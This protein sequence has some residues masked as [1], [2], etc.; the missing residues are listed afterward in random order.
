MIATM[1]PVRPRLVLAALGM[2]WLPWPGTGALRAQKAV[3]EPRAGLEYKPPRGWVELP[4]G[5][6]RGAT[7]RLHAAPRALA[8]KAVTQTPLLRVMVFA[9]GGDADQDVVDGLPRRT[10]FR[11]LEDFA[12]RG[13][14]AT[15]VDRT[16]AKAGRLGGDRLVAK[17]IAGERLLIGQVMPAAT[18]EVAVCVEVVELQADKIGKEIEAV[19]A[20]LGAVARTPVARREPPWVADPQ[21][22]ERDA[23]ARQAARRGWAEQIVAATAAAPEAGFKVQPAK[24]WTVLAATDAAFTKKAIAAAEAARA[25]FAQKLPTLTAT[26]PLPAVLRIFASPDHW[27]AFQTTRDDQ[28]EYDPTRRELWFVPDRDLGASTGYGMLFRAVLW[29]VL[30]DVDPAVLAG[31]PRWLD[32]GCWEFLRSSRCEGR[33][34]EFVPSDVERGRID[35]QLRGKTMPNL[36][37]LMQEHCQRSP[38]DGAAEPAWGYTPECA[39]LLRWFWLGDGQ[40]AFGMPDLVADYVRGIVTAYAKVGP[41]PTRDV[42]TIGLDAAQQQERNRRFY[43]WRDAMLVAINDAATPLQPDVWRA[44]NTRWLAYVEKGT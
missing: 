30:D 9:P 40:Q 4:A 44:I 6:D 24:H 33:T 7:V 18:G 22:A 35:Y 17:G 39:R 1:P 42:A 38:A 41:D 32:N 26:E 15:A 34:I 36:W 5:G 19:F 16:P 31:L 29:H 10:P 37:D 28:R 8:G 2:L 21:W 23:A 25:F 11:G 12:R 3:A 13:L 20:S 27:Q 14:G 43:L